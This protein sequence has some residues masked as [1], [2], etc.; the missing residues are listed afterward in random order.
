MDWLRRLRANILCADRKLICYDNDGNS[1]KVEG[2]KTSL[3][4]KIMSSDR[5]IKLDRRDKGIMFALYLNTPKD[6]MNVIGDDEFP[7]FQEF[8]GVFPKHCQVYF[9]LEESIIS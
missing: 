1:Y 6:G 4:Y 5:F 9:H 7:I 2:L 8:K 3:K